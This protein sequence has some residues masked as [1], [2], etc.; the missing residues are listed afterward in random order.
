[1]RSMFNFKY[2]QIN[3][4]K[5]KIKNTFCE[6]FLLLLP[7]TTALI[8]TLAGNLKEM[9]KLILPS[10]RRTFVMEGQTR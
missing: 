10:R 7:S 5:V 4:Q 3:I 9:P 8:R 6:P 2:I 1:M